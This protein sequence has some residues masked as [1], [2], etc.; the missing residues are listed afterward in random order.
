MPGSRAARIVMTVVTV[1]IVMGLVAS[2]V[3]TP[4][5]R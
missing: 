3:A 4:A 2:L 5:A 1:I